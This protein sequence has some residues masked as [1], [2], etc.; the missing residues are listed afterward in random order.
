MFLFL[1][2]CFLKYGLNLDKAVLFCLAGKISV[3]VP[4]LGFACK[5]SEQIFLGQTTL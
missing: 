5:G 3:A 4:R 2:G 1:I